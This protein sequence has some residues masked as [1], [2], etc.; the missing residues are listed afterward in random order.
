[1]PDEAFEP[2]GDDEPA[3]DAL[4][5]ALARCYSHIARREHSVAELRA[6]LERARFAPQTIEEALATVIEQ[7]Y[8]NDERYAQLLAEDRRTLDGWGVER[9]RDRMVRAGIDRSLI[10]ITL[11]PFD[12]ASERD[13]ALAVLRRRLPTPPASPAERQRAF[14]LL[15]RQ[16]FETDIAYDAVRLHERGSH[17]GG[18]LELAS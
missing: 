14:A 4:T 2:G 8:V 15:V 1:M 12:A 6:R 9:I 17:D 5:D 13:A 11:A 18:D 10:E 7:G 16:G 3:P